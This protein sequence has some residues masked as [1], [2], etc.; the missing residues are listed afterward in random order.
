MHSLCVKPLQL[1]TLPKYRPVRLPS[2]AIILLLRVNT[3]QL[4]RLVA[5]RDEDA[6]VDV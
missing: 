1:I 6:E 5:A 4:R 2:A 3:V